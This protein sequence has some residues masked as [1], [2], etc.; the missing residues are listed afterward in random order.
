METVKDLL[1][2]LNGLPSDMPIRLETGNIDC[3]NFWLDDAVV[4]DVDSS[5]YPYG[6]LTL[7]GRL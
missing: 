4:H 3:D 2:L 7:I 5:G 6:E 1:A